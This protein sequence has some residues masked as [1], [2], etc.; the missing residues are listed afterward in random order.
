MSFWKRLRI[1]FLLALLLVSVLWA[2]AHVRRHDKSTTS[3]SR[4]PRGWDQASAIN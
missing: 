4:P 2:V 1:G 3:V